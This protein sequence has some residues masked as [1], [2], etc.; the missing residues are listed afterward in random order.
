MTENM[1]SFG[2]Y[3]YNPREKLNAEHENM[4]NENHELT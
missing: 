3:G 1:K 4:Q 2:T